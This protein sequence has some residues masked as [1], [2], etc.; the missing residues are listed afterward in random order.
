MARREFLSP[1]TAEPQ[2]IILRETKD[3]EERVRKERD[4]VH[5]WI[6]ALCGVFFEPGSNDGHYVTAGIENKG[7]KSYQGNDR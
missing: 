1:K 5:S 2:D 4:R 7:R 6:P 3:V